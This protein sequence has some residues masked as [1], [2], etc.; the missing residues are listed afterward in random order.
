MKMLSRIGSSTA[1]GNLPKGFAAPASTMFLPA[2]EVA[3]GAWRCTL[4]MRGLR[5]DGVGFDE[6][7]RQ[8]LFG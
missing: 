8:P 3:A 6:L 4:V 5:G 1:G 2:L 7:H